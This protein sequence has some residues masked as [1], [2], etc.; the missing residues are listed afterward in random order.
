MKLE[1]RRRLNFSLNI[2][3]VKRKLKTYVFSGNFDSEAATKRVKI[4]I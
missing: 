2:D 3:L 1:G 4:V